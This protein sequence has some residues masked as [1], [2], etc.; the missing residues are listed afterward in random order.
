MEFAAFQL[1]AIFHDK[2]DD[3]NTSD[4]D[5]FETLQTRK[6]KWTPPEGQFA[7]LDFFIKKCRHDIN[8]LNFN[9]NTKF[10]NL[11]S[12]ERAALENLSKRKDLI[13]KAADKGGALV[14]WRAV[15]Y[16]KEA[17]WQLSDTSFYAKVDKD[18]TSTNQ[19]IVKNTINDLIV[20]QELP[21]TASNLIIT[22]PRTSCIYFLPKIHKPNNPGRPIVSACSCP[23]ELISSYLDKIMAPIVRSLPSYVK[24]SQHAL[25]I[26]RDFNFLG[27]DK[28]IFTMDIT[29]LYTVIPNGEGLLAL[30]HFFDLRTV[31]EP[32]SETLLRLAELVLTLNCFS[33]AG[34]YYKQ[35]NGVAM[36]TKMGPSYANLFVGYIE[37]KFF[38]QYNGPKPELHRCY[39]DDCVGATSSTREELS[40]FITAVNLYH[41]ALK[42]TWEIS[43]SSLAFLDIKL[44]IEG[45]GLCTSVHYK[46]TD[47]HSYLLYSSSH[48]SHVK[49]SIPYSQLLRLRRLC[50]EDSDF[51]L[52]S[53]EMCHF[54]DKHGYPASV[55]QAGHHRAQQIDRQSALQTSQKENNN[56]IPFTLTFHPHNH[57]V[58]S[59]ILKNFEL[60]QNDP[61]TGVIFSQPPL[62]SFKRDKNIGN[63]LVGSA[64]QTSNQAGTFKCA[65]A[66]CKTCP[67]I[68]NVEKL[69]GPKRSIKITDH[70]T[71]TSTNVIYCIT[72]TLCKKLY[73]GETGRRLGD[74]FREHLRDIEKDDKNASK[75]VAR[76]FNLPNHSKQ[77]MVVCG[78]SLHQGSTE[79]RKTQEQKFIFQI[80]TLNPHGINEH[81]S[82]N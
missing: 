27:E 57:A 17:L 73:I 76:H 60:L 51:S 35:I 9:H 71:C 24:D 48:P 36:G 15:L 42:Y 39:I 41:P 13:V 22:T 54:F 55:V 25:Q 59:I 56:R 66:R 32:S 79:S 74:R 69:S 11:S 49:N 31:K 65:R 20:K 62:I 21:A 72:C 78:L 52:K 18:L 8:K 34:S 50:S 67:F 19:Q 12:E 26:F 80:S 46:P 63:F 6:S 45:N 4:K 1:K 43:D 10:S 29:S 81:F 2:E 33:F 68:C 53:E 7:S 30:K 77:H 75:P 70:F 40:Q 23:T 82:F 61:D 14:V 28:L 47:S 37:H 3:S 44:S 16:Q 38:H 58:K 5:I 64:F